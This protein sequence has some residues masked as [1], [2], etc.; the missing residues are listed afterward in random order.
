MEVFA[1]GL[2]GDE[3]GPGTVAIQAVEGGKHGRAGVRIKDQQRI[4]GAAI[5]LVAAGD[6]ASGHRDG[7]VDVGG[8]E[9]G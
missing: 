2:V 4:G 1:G 6:A 7:G 5:G 8:G 9:V 3:E